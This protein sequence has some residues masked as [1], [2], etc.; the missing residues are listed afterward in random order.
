AVK[1]FRRD[2][3]RNPNKHID[4]TENPIELFN[5]LDGFLAH[6][7]A[8]LDSLA[9]SLEPLLDA[10]FHAWHKVKDQSGL[11]IINHLQNSVPDKM[12]KNAEPLVK[13][14][15]ANTGWITYLVSLR[16]SPV[17]RGGLKTVSEL[18]FD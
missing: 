9:K 7:K 16:D 14:L 4:L 12:K 10:K 2:S 13:F 3:Q 11:H 15:L 17:H 1:K 8:A 6:T 5:E 18:R